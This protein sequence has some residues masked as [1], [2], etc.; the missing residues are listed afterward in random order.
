MI[1][2]YYFIDIFNLY[3]QDLKKF[4]PGP[5]VPILGSLPFFWKQ[6]AGFN[7]LFLDPQVT[8]HKITSLKMGHNRLFIIN[9]FDVA[10]DLFNKT[11]FSGRSASEIAR[12]H[13]YRNK[14]EQGVLNNQG[15]KWINQRRYALKMLKDF[16]FG[17]SAMED[18]ILFEAEEMIESLENMGK[19]GQD[20]KLSSDFNV[21]I[22]NNLWQIVHGTR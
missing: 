17:K 8:K 5:C 19:N 12:N 4:P 7:V 11:E 21:P 9:D 14:T 15:D 22:I 2:K 3:L 1:V 18:S 13:R 6:P 10:K 20:I 16:G